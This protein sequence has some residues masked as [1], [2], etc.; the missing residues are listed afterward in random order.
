MSLDV[1][2]IRRRWTSYDAGVTL[3]EDD[4]IVYRTNITHNLGE[5]ANKAGIYEAL[6]RPYQLKSNYNKTNH[7]KAERF[8][9]ETNSVKASEI[10][11]IIQKGLN[12][13][14]KRP[15][16][17]EKFNSSNGWGMYKHFVPFVEEY[18]NACIEYPESIV[19]TDR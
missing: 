14:K 1:W 19:K 15:K 4:E 3:I 11:E 18:L 8:F 17:F 7:P 2:L 9:E 13:L 6:W 5:M 10:I 12:D 16:Y